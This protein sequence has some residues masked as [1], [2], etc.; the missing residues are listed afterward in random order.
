MNKIILLFAIITIASVSILVY[1]DLN[2]EILIDSTILDEDKA[3]LTTE[4]ELYS[5]E[6][7]KPIFDHLTK[8]SNLLDDDFDG[9]YVIEEI[10]LPEGVP[11]EKFDKCV[12]YL[13]QKAFNEAN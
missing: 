10:G 6:C 11:K 4:E 9:N 8:Y 7:D 5:I 2:T 1:I 3:G 13:L 12:D